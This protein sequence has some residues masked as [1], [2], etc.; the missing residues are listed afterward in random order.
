M[1]RDRAHPLSLLTPSRRPSRR[2]RNLSSAST[3]QTALDDD[4]EADLEDV[5]EY[6]LSVETIREADE[7]GGAW[8]GDGADA[9][10]QWENLDQSERDAL[11]EASEFEDKDSEAMSRSA[12]HGGVVR[13][14]NPLDAPFVEIKDR[15]RSKTKKVAKPT[16]K[17]TLGSLPFHQPHNRSKSASS[18]NR[19]PHASSS[20]SPLPSSPASRQSSL[21]SSPNPWAA[22]D[23]LAHTLSSLLP[24][25]PPALFSSY[26]HQPAHGSTHAA[27]LAALRLLAS[28]SPDGDDGPRCDVMLEILFGDNDEDG[29][30]QEAHYYDDVVVVWKAARGDL[31]RALDVWNIY[32]DVEHWAPY[33]P[34][35]VAPTNSG[36]VRKHINKDVLASSVPP[37]P[38]RSAATSVVHSPASS[39]QVTTRPLPTTS[40]TSDAFP[41]LSHP[42]LASGPFAIAPPS[43]VQSSSRPSSPPPP[44]RIVTNAPARQLFPRRPLPQKTHNIKNRWNPTGKDAKPKKPEG[45]SPR[46]AEY[47]PAYA[48]AGKTREGKAERW[49]ELREREML[50]RCLRNEVSRPLTGVT[51]S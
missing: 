44:E 16:T 13:D 47:I 11:W 1:G 34:V 33:G 14:Q 38:L 39:P 3:L 19:Q 28:Q 8:E 7:R 21:S 32:C 9:A 27:L 20:G 17:L 41:A 31:S 23:S 36:W 2:S 42:A 45:P 51:V 40:D 18:S 37:S 29:A 6:L 5:V 26:L 48:Q 12:S 25:A 46:L 15:S 30:D 49:E 10:T 4:P 24:A 43:P 22:I 50:E 35:A